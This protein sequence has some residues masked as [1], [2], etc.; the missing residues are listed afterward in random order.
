MNIGG[1]LTDFG[2]SELEGKVYLTLLR[3]GCLTILK[4][5]RETGINRSTLYR[6]LEKLTVMGLVKKIV[7]YKTTSYQ[8]SRPEDLE[9]VVRQKE[10]EAERLRQKLPKIIEGLSGLAGKTDNE[11]RVYYFNGKR[12]LGQLLWNTLAAKDEVV[13]LGYGDWNKGVGK[14]LAEKIREEYVERGIKSRELLNEGQ[15]NEKLS[16]TDNKRYLDEL[17]RYRIISRET[18]KIDHD[19]YIYNDVFAFYY[20]LH[21]EL[22]GVEVRNR[23]VARMQK[24]IFEILWGMAEI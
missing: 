18:L 3:R 6:L 13:G 17:Y 15:I 20:V 7:D 23:E 11:T 21:G 9:L 4:I 24:Q 2:V 12:G 1:N 8:A 22:F 16:F 10:V 19:T 14:R 5:S